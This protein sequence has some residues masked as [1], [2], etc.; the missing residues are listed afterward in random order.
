[1][2]VSGLDLLALLFDLAV[3]SSVLNRQGR[4]R[5]KRPKKVYNL[6]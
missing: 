4:L 6:R 3:Q 1:M 2:P 5:R